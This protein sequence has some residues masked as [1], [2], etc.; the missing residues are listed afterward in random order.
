MSS[1]DK[2]IWIGCAHKNY[3]Q[4]TTGAKQYKRERQMVHVEDI[5]YSGGIIN[6]IENSNIYFIDF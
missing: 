6:V 3:L 4:L 1:L 2:S 5:C